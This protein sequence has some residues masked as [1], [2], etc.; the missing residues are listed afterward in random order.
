MMRAIRVGTWRWHRAS[1]ILTVDQTME[2]LLRL[3]GIDPGHWDHQFTTWMGRVHKADLP[4]VSKAIESSFEDVQRPLAVRYRVVDTDGAISWLELRAQ[5]VVD[6]DG[7]AT[8]MSGTAWDV[9][10]VEGRDAWL[11]A[12]LDDWPDP[13]LIL[14]ADDSVEWTNAAGR[15][16]TNLVGIP[17]GPIRWEALPQ[18]R[19]QGLPALLARVRLAPGS[20]DTTTVEI[21]RPDGH[22]AWYLVRAVE[23]G[24]RAT[25]LQWSDITAQTLI[26]RADAERSRD[27]E[28]LSAALRQALTTSDVVDALVAHALPMWDDADGLIVHDLTG[29]TP[30]LIGLTGHPAGFETAMEHMDWSSRLEGARTDSSRYIYIGSVQELADGWPQLMPLVDV[31]GKQAWAVLPLMVAS[32]EFGVAIITWPKPR[33]FTSADRS[34]LATVGTLAAHALRAATT[35][36]DARRRASQAQQRVAR[37]EQELLPG[38]LPELAGIHAALRHRTKP[39]ADGPGRWADLIPLP[40]GRAMA[41]VGEVIS[42]PDDTVAMG[43]LRQLVLTMAGLD[44]LPAD[45]LLA[46]VNDA[47]LRLGQRPAAQQ[48]TATCLI[49]VFDPTT[50][51][52]TLASAGHTPP[53]LVPPGQPPT[54]L[55]MPVGGLLGVAQGPVQTIE[56]DLPEGATLVMAGGAALRQG[57]AGLADA[58]AH[59]QSQTPQPALG[60]HGRGRWLEGL[61]DAL[62]SQPGPDDELVMLALDAG[63]LPADH[64]RQWTLPRAAESAADARHHVA[65]AL[66][67]WGRSEVA[68]SAEMIVT[69]LVANTVRH[70]RGL[71]I[72][73]ADTRPGTIKLRLLNLGES[74][75]LVCE[76]YD[77]AK[78][79]P[80]VRH[81]AVSDEFG[82]GLLLVETM[83]AHT[84]GSRHTP[85]G[86]VIWAK[87]ATGD[88]VAAAMQGLPDLV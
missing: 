63:R 30:R 27:L 34:L 54:V 49:A 50:G 79:V 60:D 68:D 75:G 59:H 46:H 11:A 37:L 2:D 39:G 76:V 70:A 51:G 47:I 18:L 16:F 56:V 24:G 77:G 71:G 28:A 33:R 83:S 43:I 64:V 40:G 87:F 44:L 8:G 32:E 1:G 65:T 72:D 7:T 38:P 10:A 17:A 21:E 12:L 35:L 31:G 45:D 55:D 36:E 66:A 53:V 25:S 13:I 80:Q 85:S 23:V 9:T 19:G 15:T 52:C 42:S 14:S 22:P 67:D 73:A 86:K 29:S 88:Q 4:G 3:A 58:V 5:V 6:A 74:G 26:E 48:V 20:A 61:C 41:V 82:R 84:W 57:A 62:T 78:S 69:E 81:T